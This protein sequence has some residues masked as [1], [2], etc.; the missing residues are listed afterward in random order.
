MTT[1]FGIRSPIDCIASLN[2]SLF[3]ALS[4]AP[5]LAPISSTPYFS[6]IPLES[7]S[8]AK[9]RAVCPPIV[10]RI[11]SGRSLSIIFSKVETFSGSTY[12]LSAKSGS[13]IIVAG[14]LFTRMTLYPSSFKALHAWVPE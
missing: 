4:M 14:L 7:R 9:F 2:R 10:G 11:A 5:I 8:I 3:S 6:K 1:L 13:V 12:V